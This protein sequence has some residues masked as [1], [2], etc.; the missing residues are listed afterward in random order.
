V[1]LVELRG[2]RGLLLRQLAFEPQRADA[3]PEL[4][5]RAPYT[6]RVSR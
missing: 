6:G 4:T 1:L 5:Q 3:L 2:L